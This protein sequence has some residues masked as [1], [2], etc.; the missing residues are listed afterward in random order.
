MHTACLRDRAG[1]ARAEVA[2]RTGERG[3]SLGREAKGNFEFLAALAG[4]ARDLG[5]EG[6]TL[7]MLPSLGHSRLTDLGRSF[8]RASVGD[9]AELHGRQFDVQ[10]GAIEQRAGDLPEIIL[11]FP[12]QT[13]RLAWHPTVGRSRAWHPP[14]HVLH[15]PAP[16]IP[17]TVASI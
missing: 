8:A 12:R 14:L 13:P 2:C 10:I 7:L 9:F 16:E 3:R 15:G 17:L 4:I 11:D 6:E 5:F 1:R